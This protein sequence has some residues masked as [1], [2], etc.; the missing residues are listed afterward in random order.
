MCH[1][2]VDELTHLFWDEEQ[3]FTHKV[4]NL[5]FL[6]EGISGGR[7]ALKERCKKEMLSWQIRKVERLFKIV[8]FSDFLSQLLFL[9]KKCTPSIFYF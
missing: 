1:L 3:H 7:R 8:Q 2:C 4:L 9:L 5:E 6:E